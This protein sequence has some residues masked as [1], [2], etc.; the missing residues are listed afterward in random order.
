M[1]FVSERNS[2][3]RFALVSFWSTPAFLG[4]HQYGTPRRWLDEAQCKG[5][6]WCSKLT[7]GRRTG[8]TKAA[9][10]VAIFILR[11][12]RKSWNGGCGREGKIRKKRS[13]GGWNGPAE[14]QALRGV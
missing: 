12:R 7:S 14:I 13:G 4:K 2:N 10:A 3:R 1:I 9:H 11:P 6:T 8:K 5:W